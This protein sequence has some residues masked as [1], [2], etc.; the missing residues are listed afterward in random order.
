[1]LP[2]LAQAPTMTPS[3][4]RALG[5]RFSAALSLGP[6]RPR[7]APAGVAAGTTQGEGGGALSGA[8]ALV[9][10]AAG[11]LGVGGG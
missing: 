1:V 8:A 7:A 6:T 9:E 5:L 10:R 4:L 11:A 3:E 2:L